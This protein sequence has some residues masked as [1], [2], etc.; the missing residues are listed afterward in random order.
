M[1]PI[2]ES[3]LGVISKSSS[4]RAVRA[5]FERRRRA[6]S[7]AAAPVQIGAELEELWAVEAIG[8]SEARP[9]VLQVRPDLTRRCNDQ[10]QSNS[11]Y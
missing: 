6:L 4:I 9:E 1:E 11:S 2:C 5:S 8:G 3:R 10:F 7:N